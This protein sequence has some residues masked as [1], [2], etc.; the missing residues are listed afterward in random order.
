MACDQLTSGTTFS[1]MNLHAHSSHPQLASFSCYHHLTI[2]VK[3]ACHND[4]HVVAQEKS[5]L[6][7]GIKTLEF[8]PQRDSSVSFYWCPSSAVEDIFGSRYFLA[9]PPVMVLFLLPVLCVYVFSITFY[10]FIFV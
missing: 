1:H 9:Y 8:P 2:V 5:L 7:Y 6:C 4:R 10:N 3:L